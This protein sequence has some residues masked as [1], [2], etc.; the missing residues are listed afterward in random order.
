MGK[1]FL[2]GNGGGT[3][4]NFKVVGG[5]T[6]PASPS[7]N[8]IWVNTSEKITS[9]IFT[10][11]EPKN[12]SE[13]MLWITPGTASTAAFNALQKNGIMVYPMSAKQYVSGA[14]VSVVAKSYQG[15][16]WV[17]WFVF[18]YDYGNENLDLIG[19]WV[20]KGLAFGS[21]QQNTIVPTITKN[22]NNIVFGIEATVNLGGIVYT[23]Y[24]LDLTDV[25]RIV[26]KGTSTASN[27]IYARL[28]TSI[29]QYHATNCVA[30]VICANNANEWV[31]DV[32]SLSGKHYFGFS[33]F[34]GTQ[35]IA[36]EEIHLE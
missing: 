25:K 16:E 27:S 22:D 30:S 26:I 1:C 36:V 23:Q 10:A 19:S 6:A 9:W 35:S 24:L 34:G 17:D 13:G 21:S 11:T 28:W 31:I 18:L 2:H 15:G 14:W 32:S 12:K 29:G 33:F 3:S 5:T 7:E 8:M 4:L 20:N